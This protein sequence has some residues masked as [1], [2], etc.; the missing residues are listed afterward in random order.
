VD[1]DVVSM[2]QDPN[3]KSYT[4]PVERQGHKAATITATFVIGDNHVNSGEKVAV[5]YDFVRESG[6][7]LTDDVRGNIAGKPYSLRR[8]Q[9]SLKN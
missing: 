2:S 8:H 1:F 6:L 3:I 5:Q 4:I 9:M 7:W